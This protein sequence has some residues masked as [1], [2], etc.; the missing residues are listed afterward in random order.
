MKL[1]EIL[2][3]NLVW[4]IP[5]FMLLGILY[6]NFY[7]SESL[8]SLI[9]PFTFLMV[10]PMMV[11]LNLK[12]VFSR[13][14]FKLQFITQVINFSIIPFL[15]FFLGKIFFPDSPYIILGLL[16]TSLLPTSGMTISWTGFA[17]GNMSAAVK[18]TVL[19]LI[20]GSLLAPLYLQALVGQTIRIPLLK[21][22]QQI[23]VIVFLP[24]LLGYAT[25]QFLI[26]KYGE[27]KYQKDLKQ[28]FPPLSTLGVLAIVFIAMALKAKVII[29][30]PFLLLKYLLPLVVIYSLNFLLSTLIGK[31]FFNR[32]NGIALVYGTVMRNLSIALAI[33]MTVFGPDGSEI[34]LIIALAYIIQVQAGAWYVKFTDKIFGVA[35]EPLV[36]NFVQKGIFSLH[37]DQQIQEA[38]NL[39]EEEHLHS[40]AILDDQEKYQGILTSKLIFD[41]LADSNH[42][43]QQFI[44]EIKLESLFKISDKVPL[45]KAIKEMKRKHSYKIIV[46]DEKGKDY[47]VLTETEILKKIT[48]NS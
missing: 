15:G 5:S 37:G 26:W 10:Y 21:V 48:A 20:L 16:L 19:G 13:G 28:K 33:A 32:G 45:E 18:M 47:G 31:Y 17:R 22:F 38:I 43:P 30:N 36:E 34:A 12:K 4:S 2:Q 7:N 14:D 8:K 1:L 6:G 23:A 9:I 42:N 24:M 25:Q 39:L 41:Y 44:K 27:A 46:F 29:S 40:L 11:N 35:P 3:K